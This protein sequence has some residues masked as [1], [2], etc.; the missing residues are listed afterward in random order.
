MAA[1]FSDTALIL[2]LQ[3]FSPTLDLPFKFITFLGNESFFL[4]FLPLIYWCIHRR[5]GA[6]LAIL[7]L[8]S[9]S[10]NAIAKAAFGMPRPFMVDSSVLQLAAAGGN[11]FPSGHTQGAM[12]VWSYL[13]IRFQKTWLWWLAGALILLIPLSRLYLGVHFPVDLAGGYLIGSLLVFTFFKAEGPVAEMI[14]K[15]SPA[16]SI[17]VFYAAAIVAALWVMDQGPYVV[18]TV[19]ALIGTIL[20]LFLESRWIRFQISSNP[21]KLAARYLTGVGG[22]LVI[23]IGLKTGFAG[24]EP[25]WLFRFVRYGMVGL[26]IAAGAPLVFNRIIK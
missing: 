19:A 10:V 3:Q 13:A 16:A 21:V 6:G 14:G 25:S 12:V 20:G 2:W 1:L 24:M 11:G 17:F 18:S 5:I 26:W 9:A 8:I 7:F 15:H 22:L 4:L 23:Y